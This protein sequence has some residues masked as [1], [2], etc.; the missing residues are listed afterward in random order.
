MDLDEKDS[1]KALL[2]V[3]TV[4]EVN[5]EKHIDE[6]IIINDNSESQN[7]NNYNKYAGIGENNYHRKR[8]VNDLINING[9]RLMKRKIRL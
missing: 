9:Y 6:T 1:R 8:D 7:V 5:D 3:H 4:Y 2:G